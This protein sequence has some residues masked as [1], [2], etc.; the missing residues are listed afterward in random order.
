MKRHLLRLISLAIFA[1]LSAQTQAAD[2]Q[3]YPLFCKGSKDM[4]LEIFPGSDTVN[5]NL[6]FKKGTRAVSQGLNNGECTWSDRG[7]NKGEP[8]RMIFDLRDVYLSLTVGPG[9]AVVMKPQALTSGANSK[10]AA[11]DRILS[12]VRSGRE[13]Q[14]HAYN[15]RG[16]LRVTK[17]GP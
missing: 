4:K 5:I 3:S 9:D 17:L 7:M 2:P 11:L 12:A 16:A 13:F 1:N 14:V 10:A 6:H 8:R 15:Q